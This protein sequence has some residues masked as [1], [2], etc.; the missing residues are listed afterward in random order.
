[1]SEGE[2]QQ[3]D[4]DIE[5]SDEEIIPDGLPAAKP[6]DTSAERKIIF[7]R[8]G[9]AVGDRYVIANTIQ[10][11]GTGVVYEAIDLE[12][13]KKVALKFL[14]PS[15]MHDPDAITRLRNEYRLVGGL[16]HPGVLKLYDLLEETPYGP[17]LVMELEESPLLHDRIFHGEKLQPEEVTK[18][19]L[20]LIAALEFFMSKDIV[21]KDL[22]PTN[23]FLNPES[24]KI[25]DFDLVQGAHEEIAYGVATPDYTPPEQLTDDSMH[26]ELKIENEVTGNIY[27]LGLI[28]YEM[29]AKKRLF[30]LEDPDNLIAHFVAIRDFTFNLDDHNRIQDYISNHRLSVAAVDTF[31]QK[32]LAGQENQRYE[33]FEEMK[34]G[35]I[36]AFTPISGDVEIDL[37]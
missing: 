26:E 23:I 7:E 20:D 33:T 35:L 14:R 27:R 29:I 12:T 37:E 15:L 16:D 6:K 34:A 36:A 10:T 17:A 2:F 9:Q 4:P 32:T 22:K 13:E 28:A 18:A 19:L 21:Y 3:P 31:F 11:G 1:M 5:P 8:L 25:F 30:T 24:A